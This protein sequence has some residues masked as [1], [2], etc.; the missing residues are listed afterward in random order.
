MKVAELKELLN[1]YADDDFVYITIDSSREYNHIDSTEET[2]LGNLILKADEVP[3]F[4]S[5]ESMAAACYEENK[6]S[7]SQL[8]ITALSCFDAVAE[9][10][11]VA[12][13]ET[14]RL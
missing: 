14:R 9:E 2:T 10:I 7:L 12:D 11:K 6:S 3:D 13:R 1:K 4:D 8:Q 5:I